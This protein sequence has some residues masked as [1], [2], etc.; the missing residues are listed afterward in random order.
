MG[1]LIA[2]TGLQSQC[3]TTTTAVVV[4]HHLHKTFPEQSVL[5]VDLSSGPIGPYLNDL[6][7]NSDEEVREF[8]KVVS[9]MSA[10][11]T[12]ELDDLVWSSLIEISNKFYCFKTAHSYMRTRTQLPSDNLQHLLSILAKTFD[13]VLVDLGQITGAY[14]S[15]VSLVCDDLVV[16]GLQN[17]LLLKKLKL[18]ILTDPK[19]RVVIS[20][21]DAEKDLEASAIKKALHSH[22]LFTLPYYPQVNVA[23]NSNNL[24]SLLDKNSPYLQ[25]LLGLLSSLALLSEEGEKGGKKTWGLLKSLS[26]RK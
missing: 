2:F 14:A 19:C 5:L 24:E 25:S 26:L 7:D 1:R 17:K 21:Y 8:E 20:H 11:A 4:A 9:S 10:S 6:L 18:P 13:Y 15:L 12:G 3:A 23:Y 16:L 22:S